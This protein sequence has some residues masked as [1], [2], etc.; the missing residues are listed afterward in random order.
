MTAPRSPLPTSERFPL[1]GEGRRQD[2]GRM[3]YLPPISIPWNVAE[4]AYKVYDRQNT[5]GQTLKRLAE[6]GG[7]GRDEFL[8]LLRLADDE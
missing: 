7:F 6:R 1:Q 5:N 4:V 3:K 8:E 2:D